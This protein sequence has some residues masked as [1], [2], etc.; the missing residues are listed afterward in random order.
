MVLKYLLTWDGF[1]VFKSLFSQVIFG[2]ARKCIFTTAELLCFQPLV[3][4]NVYKKKGKCLSVLHCANSNFLSQLT[5]LNHFKLTF[6]LIKASIP[7]GF[8]CEYA[9]ATWGTI[10]NFQCIDNYEVRKLCLR[11]VPCKK[12][13][14]T[15]LNECRENS[16][17]E[18]RGYGSLHNFTWTYY[19]SEDILLQR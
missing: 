18:M 12:Y 16:Q 5:Q 3:R 11:S 4:M 15:R 9:I 19:Y 14:Q 17:Y 2:N 1:E 13:K 6:F 8:Y 10:W 7:W